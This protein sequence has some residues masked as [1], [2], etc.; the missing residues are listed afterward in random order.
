MKSIYEKR[1]NSVMHAS[2]CSFL[3]MESSP[4]VPL[5]S[6]VSESPYKDGVPTSRI[7]SP[8]VSCRSPSSSM[9]SY[10]SN[11][12]QS[13]DGSAVLVA[14]PSPNS[15][16]LPHT[17]P[18]VNRT[19]TQSQCTQT[20]PISS[21]DREPVSL[22]MQQKLEAVAISNELLKTSLEDA[23]KQVSSLEA[24][25]CTQREE[26]ANK[27]SQIAAISNRITTLL[28]NFE[29]SPRKQGG[30]KERGMKRKK[31]KKRE[32]ERERMMDEISSNKSW[33]SCAMTSFSLLS[34]LSD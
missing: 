11:S 1:N 22:H 7:S 20:T 5:S 2:I 15:P 24:T 19:S 29:V 23:R 6:S 18:R 31:M 32:R 13:L 25:I 3:G 27:E 9:R 10:S 17:S 16:L 30:K 4:L 34:D 8:S 12:Y 26:L 14:S 21:H 33:F 28:R